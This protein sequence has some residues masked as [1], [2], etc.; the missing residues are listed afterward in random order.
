MRDSWILRIVP[1][2]VVTLLVWSGARVC[3]QAQSNEPN[4]T[5]HESFGTTPDVRIR[6]ENV[7]GRILVTP[8]TANVVE[9]KAVKSAP[10]AAALAGMSVTISKDGSPVNDVDIRTHYDRDGRGG[11]VEYTL[12]VPRRA[13]LR[14]SNVMGNIVANGIANDMTL[15]DVAGN[16]SAENSDGSVRAHT[17]NGAIVV[18]VTSF[19][20]GRS[21][22]LH[23][24][25]GA[26]SLTVPHD[27]GAVV[28][29]QT[30]SGGFQSDFPLTV[31]SEMV[32]SHANGRIGTGSGWIDLESISGTLQ[33]KSGR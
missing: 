6:L 28:K 20:E 24:V 23:T 10:D 21:V 26:I 7:S 11:S 13:V 12:S 32:G 30:T 9:I 17:I 25:S 19:P 22:S 14:L 2:L 29:A 4:A 8:S 3:V 18:S 31:K 27:A 1:M 5:V 33:L 15:T 16:L